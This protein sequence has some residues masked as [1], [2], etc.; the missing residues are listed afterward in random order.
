MDPIQ[1]TSLKHPKPWP[2]FTSSLEIPY[3]TPV[4]HTPFVLII[5]ANS[6]TPIENVKHYVKL[7]T[8]RPILESSPEDNSWEHHGFQ[9]VR[10][11]HIPH[12]LTVLQTEFRTA[13]IHV[14]D[15]RVRKRDSNFPI[16]SDP[17]YQ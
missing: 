5:R 16:R 11:S 6:L 12:I 7:L 10:S 3:T 13:Q 4:N 1:E 2:A 17:E 9:V 15:Y 14:L 8:L